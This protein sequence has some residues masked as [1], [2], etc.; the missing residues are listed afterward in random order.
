MIFKK[1]IK[2]VSWL[3]FSSS[4]TADFEFPGPDFVCAAAATRLDFEFAPSGQISPAFSVGGLPCAIQLISISVNSTGG[5]SRC[6]LFTSYECFPR[7]PARGRECLFNSNQRGI[8]KTFCRLFRLFFLLASSNWKV[9]LYFYIDFFAY[10]LKYVMYK[11]MTVE[12]VTLYL[13]IENKRI[14]LRAHTFEIL[15]R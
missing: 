9:N 4:Y 6:E 14:T 8:I 5:V 3:L 10:L 12:Y 2:P 11:W 1:W 13:I 7:M 15:N